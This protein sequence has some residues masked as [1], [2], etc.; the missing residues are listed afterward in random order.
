MKDSQV[1]AMPR[2]KST[3][4]VL[5]VGTTP[6]Q[7]EVRHLYLVSV[8]SDH[9]LGYLVEIEWANGIT[10]LREIRSV[11]MKADELDRQEIVLGVASVSDPVIR[12]RLTVQRLDGSAKQ[13]EFQDLGSSFMVPVKDPETE[14]RQL[15]LYSSPSNQ[16]IGY[17]VEIEWGN[18]ITGLREMRPVSMKAVERDFHEIVLWDASVSDPVMRYRL[19]VQRPGGSDEQGEFQVL[20]PGHPGS[21]SYTVVVVD[22]TA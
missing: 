8:P 13:G 16:A 3:D 11:S 20:E 17:L 10:G 1:Y 19:T 5:F 6:A 12:Y 22:P 15:R 9:V 18:G 4:T 14:R 2:Q 21:D 7:T